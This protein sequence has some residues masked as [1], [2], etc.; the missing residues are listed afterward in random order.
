MCDFELRQILRVLPCSHEFHAKCVDKWLRVSLNTI[1]LKNISFNFNFSFYSQIEL[2][3]Y[4]VVMPQI[5][6]I[7]PNANSKQIRLQQLQQQQL[8]TTVATPITTII[9]LQQIITLLQ[10]LHQQQPQ[11]QS[12]QLAKQ[13]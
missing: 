5:I 13:Q 8:L 4:A 3:P 12:K 11:H 1:N 9:I 10:L 6:L 7:I 2:V